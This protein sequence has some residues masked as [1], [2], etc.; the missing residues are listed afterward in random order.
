MT[1]ANKLC[2]C[3]CIS[4]FIELLWAEGHKQEGANPYAEYH[5]SMFREST[6]PPQ[7][8]TVLIF[9]RG[10][11]TPSNPE[12]NRLRK[13]ERGAIVLTNEMKQL[14]TGMQLGDSHIELP[15]GCKKARLQIMQKEEVQHLYNKL[16]LLG[17]VGTEPK[18]FQIKESLAMLQ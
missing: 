18:Q 13:G 8:N 6:N 17:I 11:R 10:L 7:G 12:K 2:R 16:K 1:T 15:R 9:T 4:S 5:S 3:L 14:I